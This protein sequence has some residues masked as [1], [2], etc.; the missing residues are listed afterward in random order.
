GTGGMEPSLT[1]AASTV[2]VITFNAYVFFFGMSW[3]PVV[4][5]LLG[6][7]FPNR[8]GAA[9]LALAASAQWIANFIVSTA[10]PPI[11]AQSLTI[12]YGIFTAFALAS[13][14]F[15]K[16]KVP[17]TTGKSLEQIS[18]EEAKAAA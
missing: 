5:V 2:A 14:F 1:G 17:E 15:V 6:E 8:I 9:A 7:L 12:A 3:G 16:M 4:W 11:A 10:F 13:I 18:E